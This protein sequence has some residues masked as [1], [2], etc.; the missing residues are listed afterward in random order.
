MKE[1][2][3]VLLITL[4]FLLALGSGLAGISVKS[5]AAPD[6]E[7]PK[8]EISAE[9]LK[10]ED[11]NEKV[12]IIVELEG[13]PAIS[14]ATE[15][16]MLYK[17]MPEST[18]ES[19]EAAIAES[20]KT[21]KA[22][23]SKTAP[24]TTYLESFSAVFN[25]FSAEL[26]AKQVEKIAEQEGIKAIFK[27]TEYE[28]PAANPE[29][30]H[31]KELVQAQQVWN[32]Y[33]LRGEGTVVGII[34]TGIDPSHKD[35]V[36]SDNTTAELTKAE[37]EALVADRALLN[38]KF[39][40][41]KVPF[42]YNYMDGN[43]EIRDIG[44]GAT[45]HGMHVA[46]TV[47][48]N[49][50]EE[51]GGV[52]GVAPETQL[53]ALKVFS[54]DPL[55]PSTYGDIYVKAIDDAIKLG[56]DV[57]NM[58]IGA[59]AGFVDSSDPEQQAVERATDNGILV[60]VSA[61]NSN[62]LGSGFAPPLAINQDYGLT[63][64]PS[65]S[66]DSFGVAS[67]ENSRITAKS[68]A[69]NINGADAGR[70]IYFLA[71]DVD[72][73]ELPQDTYPVL[74]A[75]LGKPEEFEGKDFVNKFALIARGEI[76]F[77]QKALNAQAAGAVGVIIYNNVPGIINMAGDP[78]IRIPFL[79]ILQSDGLE[80]KEALA[81][82]SEVAVAFDGE[83]LDVA[84]PTAGKMSDF[85]SWGPT[86]NLDF[87]P[88]VTAPG[89]NIFS[90]FND[91]QYGLMSGTSM[92]APHVSGGAAL[93]FQRLQDEL[94]I[95]GVDRVQFA[96]NLLM[97]TANPI[98]FAQGQFVSPR[99]QG[100]GLMQL[101]DALSAKAMVTDKATA[102][103]KV[104]LKEITGDKLAF[105]LTAKNFSADAAT[106]NVALNVQVDKTMN[107]GG[108]RFVTDPN[109]LGSDNITGAVSITAP[110]AVTIP[111]NGEM[112]IPVSI[113]LSAVSPQLRTVFTNGFFVDGFVTLTD[114]SEE[115]TGNPALVV[116]YFG[117]NGNW[118]DADIFDEFAW[119]P[120][121]F[122]GTTVLVN[123]QGMIMKGGTHEAN[124]V[125][126]QFAFSPNGDGMWDMIYPYFSLLRNAKALEVNVLDAGGKK[127]RTIRS[128]KKLT[129]NF[130]P[131]A[132]YIANPAY[133]W[134]GQVL[135]KL[136]EDGDYQIQLRAVIDY[137]DAEWQSIEFPV[138]VDTVA[139]QAQAAYNADTATVEVAS[140]TDTEEGAGP[141]RW[142]VFLNGTELTEDATT[143]A[144]ESLAPAT[145][146]FKLPAALKAGDELVA[147]FYDVAGNRQ[148]V[149]L[150]A[151]ASAAAS[152]PTIFIDSPTALSI[153]NTDKIIVSG[154]VE[155]ESKVASVTV[156]G[157][158]ALQFDGRNFN[159]TLALE[160]GVQEINVAAV[161]DS[162]NDLQIRRQIFVDTTA[163]EL[164][165]VDVPKSVP[166]DQ[167][168]AE[169]T[170]NVKDNFDEIR[171]Y[172]YDSE[173]YAHKLSTPYEVKNFD[174]EVTAKIPV[175]EEGAN[176]Y[177]LIATDL[178]GN[179]TEVEF[180]ITKEAE[181][182]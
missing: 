57:I 93:L 33:G 103:A 65:V 73:V 7:N 49:G 112:E 152:E 62:L 50:N 37:V 59:T 116:P 40:T 80:M 180:S 150:N 81:A 45:M 36:L 107:G 6:P 156:N 60:S 66:Y 23:I 3:T 104:A 171:V 18:K 170:F 99:R 119:D 121:T 56:A 2:R 78:A 22:A 122:Y 13:A 68:F 24:D 110:Q 182:E 69:K 46:G 178:A 101:H 90:T 151:A 85:T 111:A 5:A 10:P 164:T 71:N 30:I 155:D 27:A 147:I 169:I 123:N 141:D 113:D 176:D 58:S 134:N 106:Y 173:I 181:K 129:K 149:E 91:D 64:S 47:G 1:W 120:M 132:A 38:G 168:E 131:L 143:P 109:T 158:P 124:F 142:E 75:G 51:T 148:Q 115:V 100:A 137:P 160:D 21:V 54:N 94:K 114:A 53:L 95:D 179:T 44:A 177:K 41:E 39:F 76:T 48:A 102:E 125:P 12:R 86:P 19:L 154:H 162:G 31:S 174:E 98:E 175:L 133:G 96:K 43:N 84:S 15:K 79:S 35:M 167:N 82:G 159:H 14:N 157:E 97:N 165:L 29:M 61:G 9:L 89:G 32:D 28:R 166:K 52:K 118:N 153:H 11:P 108:T 135:G 20:Q 105:T 163:A 83:Y 161:D 17:A 42:G 70:S 144:D 8:A 92:A 26:E 127:L 72:P 25:G 140:F 63:G 67:F 146:N 87:K 130:S 55:N 136:V 16:G 139:P 138:I 172:V 77:A 126:E 145:R 128:D 117:F 88:E 74:D 4:V 34:D